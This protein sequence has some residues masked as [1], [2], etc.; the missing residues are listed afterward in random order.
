[1]HPVFGRVSVQGMKHHITEYV[2]LERLPKT[3]SPAQ[4]ARWVARYERALNTST[5]DHW[6]VR[7]TLDA[8]GVYQA[9]YRL[10]ASVLWELYGRAR[11]WSWAQ[12]LEANGETNG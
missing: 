12:A 4:I 3:W 5:G 8:P 1:L 7:V 9:W 11:E 2:N 10:R 6:T